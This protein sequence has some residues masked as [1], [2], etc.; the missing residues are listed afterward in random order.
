MQEFWVCE[1]Y[2][3]TDYAGTGLAQIRKVIS[4]GKTILENEVV[5]TIQR[6]W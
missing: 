2:I 5:D 3:R 1:S 6:Y 4:V